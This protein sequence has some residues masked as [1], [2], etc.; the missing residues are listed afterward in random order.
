MEDLITG[1]ASIGLADFVRQLGRPEAPARKFFQQRSP[2]PPGRHQGE[3]QVLDSRGCALSRRGRFHG[4]DLLTLHI[5]RSGVTGNGPG[6]TVFESAPAAAIGTLL[7][8]ATLNAGQMLDLEQFMFCFTAHRKGI[9]HRDIKTSNV[10]INAQGMP[11]SSDFASPPDGDLI[12]DRLRCRG[13]AVG[14]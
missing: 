5:S 11:V 13:P 9:I 6:Y 4:A 14:R 8:K 2:C 12:D 1:S 7:R 10:L 3:Q